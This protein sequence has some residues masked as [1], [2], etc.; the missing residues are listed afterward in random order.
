MALLRAVLETSFWMAAYAAEVAAN[1]FDFFE[2]IVPTAVEDEI[3]RPQAGSP[4]REYAYATLFRQLRHRMID[5]PAEAPPRLHLF[6]P[7]EAD[8][9]ALAQSSGA[10]LLINEHR[11]AQYAR[12]A[13][14][15]TVTVSA[16][17]GRAARAV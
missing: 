10:W 6:G 9:T 2:L 3:R 13:Q 11:G 16:L 12:R 4:Q 15:A 7:G 17:S 1:C 5:P 8:A 14:I